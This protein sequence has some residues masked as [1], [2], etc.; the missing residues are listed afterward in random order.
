[1]TTEKGLP[2]KGYTDQTADKIAR[3]NRHKEPDERV[4]RALDDMQEEMIDAARSGLP[5]PFDPRWAAIAKTQIEQGF[6]AMNRA[7]FQPQ[8]V[9]LPE[10]EP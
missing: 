10:D 8:R 6:M 2:V 7:V 3:V 5:S 9:S 1:M 4:L